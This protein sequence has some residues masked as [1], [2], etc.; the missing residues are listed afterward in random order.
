MAV[1]RSRLQLTVDQYST[2]YIMT[3]CGKPLRLML[4]ERVE[5][6]STGSFRC[7]QRQKFYPGVDSKGLF[8]GVWSEWSVHRTF[9]VSRLTACAKLPAAY[10]LSRGRPFSINVT[11]PPTFEAFRDFQ[12]ACQNWVDLLA[13]RHHTNAEERP[14]HIGPQVVSTCPPEL[15]VMSIAGSSQISQRPQF[16]TMS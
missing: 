3:A 9:N 6:C 10:S 1:S 5:S 4:T 12:N 7:V 14:G 2:S 15:G 11:H 13:G 16:L 8:N